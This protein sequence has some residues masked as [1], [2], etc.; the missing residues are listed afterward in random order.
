MSV[1]GQTEKYPA[2]ADVV[3]SSSNNGRWFS[4]RGVTRIDGGSRPLFRRSIVME[5]SFIADRWT[6]SESLPLRQFIHPS[7]TFASCENP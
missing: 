6:G 2:R 1:P 7:T 3:R 4:V 5:Y